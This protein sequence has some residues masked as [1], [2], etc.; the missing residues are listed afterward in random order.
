MVTILRA[1]THTLSHVT[2]SVFTRKVA[3]LGEERAYDVLQNTVCDV[4]AESLVFIFVQ[5]DKKLSSVHSGRFTVPF[6][7]EL[8]TLV[9]FQNGAQAAQRHA[10]DGSIAR[11]SQLQKDL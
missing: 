11:L 10:L 6:N 1:L 8:E 5:T 9:V 3:G 7:E 2:F 4:N